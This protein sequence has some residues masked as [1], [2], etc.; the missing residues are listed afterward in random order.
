MSHGTCNRRKKEV[1]LAQYTQGPPPSPTPPWGGGWTPTHPEI[2]PDPPPPPRGVGRTLSK[3]LIRTTH[4]LVSVTVANAFHQQWLGFGEGWG[5]KWR[6]AASSGAITPSKMGVFRGGARPW[7]SK[8]QAPVCPVRGRQGG[9]PLNHA[10]AGG[11]G[12]RR[13][14]HGGLGGSGI[15]GKGG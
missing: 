11:G 13:H 12:D 5:G 7:P 6:C 1:A 10:V 9:R 15:R 4:P 8:G 14:A 3:T 2:L